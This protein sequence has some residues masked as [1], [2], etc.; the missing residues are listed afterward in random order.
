MMHP[1]NKTFPAVLVLFAV[2]F[3]SLNG[4][5]NAQ[6]LIANG[7]RDE[8]LMSFHFV[9][10]TLVFVAGF[11]LHVHS[12]R[13]IRNLRQPGEVGYR[14]PQ[15]GMFRWISSPHYLEKSSSGP[16]GDSDLV[17]GRRRLRPVHFL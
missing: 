1:S 9:L 10:G 6:A 5:N 2:A 15:G 11:L 3:N 13:I 16:L 12:D 8:P 4:Y 17:M 14:I 7:N